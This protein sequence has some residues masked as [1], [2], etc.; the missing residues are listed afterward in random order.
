[1]ASQRSGEER[2]R[3]RKPIKTPTPAYLATAGSPL[4]VDQDLYSAIQQGPRTL[5]E[6]FTLPIRSG[7]AWKAPAKSI[8]RISTPEGAQVGK[9]EEF[10]SDVF[11][12][13]YGCPDTKA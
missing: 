10:I 4:S 9:F 1:M 2:L 7:R 6:S 12:K 5:V 11:S 8:V 3:D 13:F